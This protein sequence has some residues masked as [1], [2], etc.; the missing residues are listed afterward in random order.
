MIR[1]LHKVAILG[2]L[3]SPLNALA[4][5]SVLFIG[6]S[7][8]F[9]YGSAA[10]FY[11]ADT[12]TD[13]NNEGIGGVPALF[14]SFADQAGLDYDVYLETRG[15]SNIDFHL[16]NKLG[17]I[18]RRPWDQVVM[19]GYST[20]DAE[21]PGN[22][23]KLVASTAAMT[24][25]L[26]SKNPDVDVYL[27]ATWS[28]ADQTYPPERPWSGQPIEQ[29]ALDVRAGYDLAAAAPGVAAVNPVG[30]AWTRAMALGIADPN[31]YDGIETDKIN[32]WTWD[33]YH[34]STYGYYL[35]A[36][37][38]FGNLTGRDP[39]SLGENECSG[40]ELGMARNEVRMLQQAAFEQLHSEGKVMADPLELS[41]AVNPERCVA[42]R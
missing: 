30:E 22:P 34:A 21:E 32:L 3:M 13:L 19:H 5:T 15:G 10:R 41:Q 6:N 12:V 23:D 36:L 31:P 40:Y 38:V 42:G 29:M 11:R 9:G 33:H 20:L 8:T 28:R 26:R 17:V 35:E 16:E 24:E 1:T 39:R 14:K 2:L 37:V 18:G 4:D 25:F 27:T 7:F